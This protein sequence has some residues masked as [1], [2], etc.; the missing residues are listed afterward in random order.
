MVLVQDYKFHPFVDFLHR[1]VEPNPAALEQAAAQGA[2]PAM[3]KDRPFTLT[4]TRV[5]VCML[6]MSL[7]FQCFKY[8]LFRHSCPSRLLIVCAGDPL[9]CRDLENI[10]TEA[11]LTFLQKMFF[12]SVINLIISSLFKL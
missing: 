11:K 9:L 7:C 12:S 1:M 5:C 6:I 8:V 3:Q 10:R 2:H 4:Y